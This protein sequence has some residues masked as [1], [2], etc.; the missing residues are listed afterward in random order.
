MSDKKKTTNA[1]EILHRRYLDDKAETQ[2]TME[3]ERVNARVAQMI[4]DFRSAA[5]L[6][7]KQ[8][9]DLIGTTQSVVSRLEDADYDGHSL[10]MLNRIASALGKQLNVTLIDRAPREEI[11]LRVAF[12]ECLKVHRRSKNLTLED[13]ARRLEMEPND[14]RELEHS[15]SCKPDPYTLYRLSE[16]YK[17]PLESLSILCGAFK[18]T[19]DEIRHEASA[20]AAKSESFSKASRDQLKLVDEF[21]K[22]L[23]KK[24]VTANRPSNE[25]KRPPRD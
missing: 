10:S 21:M 18:D 15:M 3:T 5:N 11:E 1:I 19:S 22:Q 14:L 23:K 6:T 25:R 2:V 16:F 9:A 17:I 13:A 4:Y 7:Q 20:F 8:L 12:Q 24:Y